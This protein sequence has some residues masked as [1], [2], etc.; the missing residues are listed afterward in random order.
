M[1]V[2][3]QVHRLTG[4]A[5]STGL[6]LAV[7]AAPAVLIGPWAGVLI[8]RWPRRSVLV[9]ANLAGAAAVVLM[10]P[11]HVGFLLAGLLGESV[12]VCFL[13]PAL[14]AVLPAVADDLASANSL[15]ALSDSALRMIGP[16]I[17]TFLTARGWFE[18][19]VIVD[20]VSYLAAA[21]IIAGL[22][23]RPSAVDASPA[24]MRDVL[25]S[26]LLRGMLVASWVYW[27]GNAALTALLVPFTVT[28]LHG[29]GVELGYLI[30]GLGLGYVAGSA[31]SGRVVR[32][33]GTRGILTVA[34]TLVG[35]CF[36]VMVNATTIVVAVVAVTLAGAPGVIAGV[37]ITYGMQ[38]S[39]PDALLGRVA[40]TFFVSD[41]V[42]AVAGALLA[43]LVV[44]AAT[45]EVALNAFGALVVCCGLLCAVLLAGHRPSIAARVTS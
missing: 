20:A 22:A 9:G 1:A 15:T 34:Y 8:D 37:A 39:T 31:V 11:P 18:L 32:R 23:L 17:G 6:A 13:R 14:R 38:A 10:L 42:A 44:T 26:P 5:L 24:G 45:L 7:Q 3:L 25:A 2:P 19:V 33:Y 12:V 30:A 43:A 36:L 40:A 28:R 4:S 16:V 21:A 27:T 35:L 29:S 41:A